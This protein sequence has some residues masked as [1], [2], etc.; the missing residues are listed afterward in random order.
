MAARPEVTMDAK[1]QKIIQS[2]D[3]RIPEKAEIGIDRCDELYREIRIDNTLTGENGQ[4]V[5]LK[6]DAHVEVTIQADA[7]DTTPKS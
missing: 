7:K 3:P 4:E 6:Q 5:K 2:P 1:V